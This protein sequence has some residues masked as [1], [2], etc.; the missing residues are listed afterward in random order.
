[1]TSSVRRQRLVSTSET[2]LALTADSAN[3]EQTSLLK[4]NNHTIN[5]NSCMKRHKSKK[6]ECLKVLFWL[7]SF[8][9][10]KK[11]RKSVSWATCNR[12]CNVWMSDYTFTRFHTFTSAYESNSLNAVHAIV[13]DYLQSWHTNQW[14]SLRRHLERAALMGTRSRC[15]HQNPSAIRQQQF[16][17]PTPSNGRTLPLILFPGRIIELNTTST[18]RVLTCRKSRSWN[19]NVNVRQLFEVA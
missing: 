7:Y 10:Q 6:F 18:W 3:Y 4:S 12:D 16:G 5:R 17:N 8:R 13:T 14:R 2:I 9:W 1:M 15:D 11:N 19:V